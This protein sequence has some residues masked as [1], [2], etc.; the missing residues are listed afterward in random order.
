[1]VWCNNIRIPRKLPNLVIVD[2]CLRGLNKLYRCH[3]DYI[4]CFCYEEVPFEQFLL[5]TH[6]IATY[7][8]GQGN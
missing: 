2:W 1:M 7:T 5:N 3:E 4:H 8:E 6:T